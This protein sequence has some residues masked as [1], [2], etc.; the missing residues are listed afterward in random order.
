LG[1]P[2]RAPGALARCWAHPR[3]HS[4]VARRWPA[5]LARARARSW[6]RR[7]AP[8]APWLVQG[9]AFGCHPHT[10]AFDSAAV[11]NTILVSF[12]LMREPSARAGAVAS[13]VRR[14]ADMLVSSLERHV[15]PTEEALDAFA[16]AM[17]ALHA[18]AA[19]TNFDGATECAL[20]TAPAQWRPA[21]L[22]MHVRGRT[23]GL[24][25]GLGITEELQ[26]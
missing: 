12:W 15:A 20:P 26:T 10:A 24:G 19:E 1:P 23:L 17:Q 22:A 13:A 4:P 18:H 3:P 8:A 6:T 5:A 16:A 14:S 2:M 7:G 25:E 9:T 21:L 11:C